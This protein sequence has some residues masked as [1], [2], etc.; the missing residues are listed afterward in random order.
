M[1]KKLIVKSATNLPKVIL[2]NIGSLSEPLLNEVTA[3]FGLNRDIIA[4]EEAI[5]HAW[6]Q[7]PRQLGKIPIELRDER[8]LRMCVAVASG[9]FDAAINYVWNATIVELRE[10][11]RRFGLAVVPQLLDDSSFDEKRLTG[12]KDAELLDLCRKLNLIGEDDYFF[13]DQCRDT[14]NNFSV[15]H[16]AAGAVDEDEFISFLSRC[17]KHGLVQ[18]QD[19]QGV[20][21]KAFLNAIKA[22]K[23][24]KPQQEEWERR[25][26]DTFDAQ[27]ELLFG[28]LH[29]IFCDSG[30][31]EHARQN[32]RSI[33]LEF[34][35]SFS[36]K[37]ASALVDRH[38]DYKAKG[39]EVRFQ[40]SSQFFEQIGRLDLLGN[41]ELH[42]IITK[43][44]A[45]LMQV[46]QAF[47]NFYNEPPFATRLREIAESTAVPKTAQE[48]F[49]E[50]IVTCATGNPYGVCRNAI[51]DYRNLISS[52]SPAEIAIMLDLPNSKTIVGNRIRGD[53][54]C[55]RRFRKCVT[56]LQKESVPTSSKAAFTKWAK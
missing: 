47:D 30:A 39:D 49:V 27:R 51:T 10:K 4:D 37:S 23:F 41:A 31:E 34:A 1:S 45:A 53:A 2:P 11:V 38:Q 55:R 40:A 50:V 15:A 7:L 28:T 42:A 36:P 18:S 19:P 29:G 17:R 33:C 52:F 54:D 14:R 26:A 43:A 12:L 24:K 8:L 35:D 13:L 44:C 21:T 3:A 5:E 25:L 46:H 22:G 6:G 9:L 48:P 20:D 32:A 16:P 56:L